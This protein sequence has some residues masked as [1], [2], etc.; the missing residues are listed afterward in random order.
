MRTSKRKTLRDTTQTMN[1]KIALLTLSLIIFGSCSKSGQEADT[2][3]QNEPTQRAGS[4]LPISLSLDGT[5][6]SDLPQDEEARAFAFNITSTGPELKM[7]EES[8][9]SVAII[10][11]ANKSIV[12]YININWSKTAGQNHLYFKDLEVTTDLLGK[13][14]NLTTNQRWYIMGYVGGTFS[15]TTRRVEYSPNGTSLNGSDT[16]PTVK[17]IPVAFSWTELEVKHYGQK[18]LA[19][20]K[21]R[22][23]F[24]T[25]GMMMRLTVKN[26]FSSN[27]RV[28]SIKYQSNAL[29]TT[30]GYYNLNVAN[31]PAT[32]ATTLP[33]WT[34]NNSTEP[35]YT[36]ANANGSTLNL[37]LAPNAT[38]TQS[39][40]VWGMPTSPAPTSAMT[41][42]IANVSRLDGTTEETYPKMSSLYVWGST[43]KPKERTR[44]K[45][46]A[47]VEREKMAL[48]YFAKDYTGHNGFNVTRLATVD[49]Y[50]GTAWGN[51]PLFSYTQASR[52]GALQTG[53][54][55]PA[56]KDARGL[57]NV[58][59]SNNL[60]NVSALK[61]GGNRIHTVSGQSVRVNG[62]ANTYTDIYQ[63][64]S[65]IYALRFDGNGK[66][67]YS[68][69]RY[70]FSESTGAT[71]EAV[72]LGPN[73]KGSIND[74]SQASFWVLHK[75]D[76]IKRFYARSYYTAAGEVFRTFAHFWA[77]SDTSITELG[78]S[79]SGQR[80]WVLGYLDDQ[81]IPYLA[82]RQHYYPDGSPMISNAH[83]IPIEAVETTPTWHD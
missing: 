27:V 12:Y 64:G 36:L 31:L 62:V 26:N 56:Y 51:I 79:A 43:N 52:S 76:I 8:I 60:A 54:R 65:T 28:K 73:Y 4:E 67:L 9:P 80:R 20:A 18:Q 47:I 82:H 59:L 45:I 57:Y 33:S 78:A 69:W 75:D 39:F 63:T 35:S 66:K 7:T 55:V 70:N 74:V 16:Q 15:P 17:N 40:L 34:S 3:T 1:K 22:I 13:P 41:H 46:S 19:L 81:G 72:Y 2:A 50:T 6:D 83:I 21:D 30:S 11:N 53:W 38:S 77:L 23:R 71:I 58:D 44:R 14:I 48:E 37:D 10:S 32:T 25:L 49:R 68:A 29:T 24:K 5:L 42:V 61:F